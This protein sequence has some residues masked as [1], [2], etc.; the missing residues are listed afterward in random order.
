VVDG[1]DCLALIHRAALANAVDADTYA[2]AVAET[3]STGLTLDDAIH[4]QLTQA[5]QFLASQHENSR[6]LW[7]PELIASLNAFDEAIRA[8]DER[9][10]SGKGTAGTPA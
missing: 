6:E 7:D 4:E 8:A 3:A 5:R 10:C 9:P 1:D 2:R